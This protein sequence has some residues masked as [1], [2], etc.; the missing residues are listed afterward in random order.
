MKSAGIMVMFVAMALAI[1][2]CGGGDDDSGG[3]GPLSGTWTGTG[4]SRMIGTAPT[5][6]VLS[7]DGNQLSGT[8]DGYSTSGTVDGQKVTLSIGPVE[9]DGVTMTISVTGTVNGDKMNLAGT[10]TGTSSGMTISDH[11]SFNL[12]KDTGK[13][14][15]TYPDPEF[16]PL[17]VKRLSPTK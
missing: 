11:V 4:T 9:E 14:V 5:T 1:T 2:G 8:W 6:L 12:A 16:L 3:N 10:V 15:A 7:Q 17:V 13:T